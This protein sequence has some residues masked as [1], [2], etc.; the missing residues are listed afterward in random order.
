MRVCGVVVEQVVSPAQSTNVH[1]VGAD[2][3][4]SGARELVAHGSVAIEIDGST[5]KPGLHRRA[6]T[7]AGRARLH[8]PPRR[9]GDRRQ[10][11]RTRVRRRPVTA[12]PRPAGRPSLLQIGRAPRRARAREWHRSEPTRVGDL[13]RARRSLW[14]ATARA[15]QPAPE[16]VPVRQGA[17]RGRAVRSHRRGAIRAAPVARIE[18]SNPAPPLERSGSPALR[19][20][21]PA[22]AVPLRGNERHRVRCR[23]RARCECERVRSGYEP[24]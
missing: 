22:A 4:T 5:C 2:W 19:A 10:L 23:I 8:F 16:G 14:A 24:R 6:I 12:R 1:S 13:A 20:G 17:T 21:L 18:D 9:P 7:R 3:R 15:P 11:R